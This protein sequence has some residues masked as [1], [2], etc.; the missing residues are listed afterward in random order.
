MKITGITHICL[1]STD[2]E[3]TEKFYCEVLGMTLKFPF[4]RDGKRIGIYLEAAPRQFIE[5]FLRDTATRN[6]E[7][8]I[9]HVCLETDDIKALAKHLQASGIKTDTPEPIMGADNSWQIWCKD[10]DG[11]PI[12]FHHFTPQSN[13]LTGKPCIATW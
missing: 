9:T 6:D 8:Q 2:L 3:R 13:Q 4:M 12:E 10:P 7:P 11:T 1:Y 5:V